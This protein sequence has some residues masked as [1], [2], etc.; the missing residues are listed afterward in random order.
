MLTEFIEKKNMTQVFHQN[1]MTLVSV[2]TINHL[3]TGW[4]IVDIAILLLIIACLTLVSQ[5]E[6]K[7]LVTKYLEKI[8]WKREKYSH[9][10]IGKCRKGKYSF[11]YLFS[12]NF[13]AL[14]H[15]M[16]EESRITSFEE[17]QT[18]AFEE[19]QSLV[20]KEIRGVRLTNTIH[21]DV[22][23]EVKES[24]DYDIRMIIE[25]KES[26]K[27][28]Q[29]YLSMCRNCYHQRITDKFSDHH[30]YLSPKFNDEG[31][32]GW[33][34]NIFQS[35][36]TFDHI[37]FERKKEILESIDHFLHHPE[38]YEKK[39]IPW[40]LGILLC[41]PPGTGKTSFIKAMINYTKRHVIEVPLDKVKKDEDLKEI[42]YK[43]NI[44]GSCLSYDKRIY[45]I[46]D[47]DCLNENLISKRSPDSSLDN[48]A[49]T[50]SYLP[51]SKGKF[52]FSASTLKLS[53]LLNVIDGVMEIP[54]R[55]LII[56]SNY[57]EKLDDALIRKGRMDIRIDMC[58]LKG[59]VLKEMIKSL[60]HETPS[61]EYDFSNPKNYT[62]AEV[63]RMCLENTLQDTSKS[64]SKTIH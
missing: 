16:I 6:I 2:N 25:S 4:I 51:T 20:P 45:L 38:W 48:D 63:E 60:Y 62:P 29:K 8:F 34:Q 17:L 54:G 36:K 19:K 50:L 26:Y 39:G 53:H 14:T 56:S 55:I 31:V 5:M 23:K 11:Y 7:Q 58:S 59:K 64:L 57:P 61:E 21:L 18:S 49:V 37:Y 24:G 41:G 52:S 43:Q 47:I 12:T 46:E 13:K 32:K 35:N 27:D 22:M 33:K 10:I 42:F 44:L 3:K 9:E 28:I 1:L 40:T 30:W 15:I